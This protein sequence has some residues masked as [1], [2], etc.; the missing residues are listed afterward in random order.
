MCQV[1]LNAIGRGVLPWY[2][3]VWMWCFVCLEYVSSLTGF[4]KQHVAVLNSSK[5]FCVLF[6]PFVDSLLLWKSVMQ[7][8]L[9]NLN[10]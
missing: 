1:K 7:F 4:Q 10:T 3:S 2:N 9:W 6:V 5:L 8:S